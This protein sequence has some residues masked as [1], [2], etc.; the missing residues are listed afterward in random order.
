MVD[1]IDSVQ[2]DT[3]GSAMVDLFEIDMPGAT[4]YFYPGLEGGTESVYYPSPDGGVSN[5]YLAIPMEFQGL[6]I[7]SDGAQPRPSLSI[8]NIVG[9]SSSPEAAQDVQPI[10]VW[11]DPAPAV[12][13]FPWTVGFTVDFS[14]SGGTYRFTNGT[15]DVARAISLQS[16]QMMSIIA[17]NTYKVTINI[18]YNENN[19]NWLRVAVLGTEQGRIDFTTGEGVYELTFVANTTSNLA[20]IQIWSGRHVDIWFNDIYWYEIPSNTEVSGDY[21]H[22]SGTSQAVNW[23]VPAG[24]YSVNALCI[25]GGGAASGYDATSSRWM[26]G[27]GGGGL[28]WKNNIPVTPGEQILIKYDTL[29]SGGGVSYFKDESTVAGYGGSS[30]TG[31]GFVGDGGGNGGTGGVGTSLGSFAQGG[32]GAGAGGYTAEGGNGGASNGPGG[33]GRSGGGGGGGGG[34]QGTGTNTVAGDGGG[35]GIYG[36][37]DNGIGGAAGDPGAQG[38][39]GSDGAL[40]TYGGGASGGRTVNTGAGGHGM[41]RVMWGEGRSFPGDGN[42]T[43]L[44]RELANLNLLGNEQLIGRTVRRRRTLAEHL[45]TAGDAPV[46]P[47]ELPVASYVI[48]RIASENNVLVNFELASPLDLEGVQIPSRVVVGKYCSWEYQGV[49][50]LKG[51]G[52]TWNKDSY[53]F[54]PSSTTGVNYGLFFFD[55]DDRPGVD[56]AIGTIAYDG[57][58]NQD[59]IV[60]YQSKRWRCEVNG[61]TTAP[62]LTNTAWQVM[63]VYSDYSAAS[64]Y[65]YIVPP[66]YTAVFYDSKLW[67][68]KR[69][70][71][72][73]TPPEDNSY[74][75]SRVDQC[76]KLVS[77]CKV[78]YQA[79]PMNPDSSG[80][81]CVP[82]AVLRTDGVLFFGGFPG[83]KKFR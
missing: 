76:G 78:R 23:T 18:V 80:R 79:T 72:I 30:R 59:E 5:Q 75:W 49:S 65:E 17:G 68:P 27:G 14:V 3:P 36:R 51:G 4:L 20:D 70:V 34:L 62:S 21:I 29:D 46:V 45:L 16:G 41:T 83:T 61:T 33:D 28:G 12:D 60:L 15:S 48:E 11:A 67:T 1:I 43:T 40:A 71:P 42:D 24:V 63:I 7:T 8:A 82:S 50:N 52:C 54:Y 26:H 6:E 74:Y 10:L 9:G 25:G 64:T 58:H 39:A 55:K 66:I 56:S 77:S 31:G 2:L 47:E 69:H 22:N 19:D 13:K 37:Y 57:N 44:Y 32:G 81:S 38:G 73:S 53:Y 35:T